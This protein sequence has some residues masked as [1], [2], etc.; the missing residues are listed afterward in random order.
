M[1]RLEEKYLEKGLRMTTARRA[2]LQ[3]LQ[4]SDDHP[5]A[6]TLHV[7]AQAIDP[8]LAQATVY[9][10]MRLLEEIGLVEK[11]DFG[12]GRARYEEAGKDQHDHLINL[13]TGE[14][15]EFHDE[16]LEALKVQIADRLGFDLK[17]HRVELYGVP[18]VK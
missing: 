18:K 8:T 4:A 11:H 17:D 9:R 12:N 2:I 6:L 7:R 3:A 5:D 16:A 14:I 13:A 10:T 1:Q 15:L